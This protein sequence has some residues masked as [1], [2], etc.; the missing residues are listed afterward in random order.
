MAKLT[1]A[2]RKKLPASKFALPG[3]KKY[4]VNDKAHAINAKARATQQEKRGNISPVTKRRVF[5]K[6]DQV[7]GHRTMS[8]VRKINGIK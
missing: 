5:K 2:A 7:I 6:A 4:P 3:I 1:T 8:P